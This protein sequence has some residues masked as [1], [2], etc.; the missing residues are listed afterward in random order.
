MK[1]KWAVRLAYTSD[2]KITFVGVKK[3][4]DTDLPCM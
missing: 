1:D 3:K 4:N 2:N